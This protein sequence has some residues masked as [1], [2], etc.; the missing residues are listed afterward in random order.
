MTTTLYLVNEDDRFPQLAKYNAV[1]A[2]ND[3]DFVPSLALAGDLLELKSTFV[4]LSGYDEQVYFARQGLKLC[5]T[6]CSIYFCTQANAYTDV[7]VV[8]DA[9][10]SRF[11]RSC[12]WD[13]HSDWRSSPKA[14]RPRCNLSG[15]ATRIPATV[16]ARMPPMEPLKLFLPKGCRAMAD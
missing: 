13:G 3:E 5:R 12:T 15:C 11:R 2:I 1:T 8:L 16:F 7:M 6:D 10:N 14:L 9:R 4:S